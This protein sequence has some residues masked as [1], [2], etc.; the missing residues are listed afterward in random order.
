MREPAAEPPTPPNAFTREFLAWRG[1]EDEPTHAGE[2]STA[3]PWK[4]E[5]APDGRH[6]VLREWE[7]LAEGFAPA[8]VFLA[9][10]PA[11]LLAALL[12]IHG[13]DPL[14]LLDAERKPGGFPLRD[15]SG[16]TVGWLAAY[17]VDLARALHLGLALLRSPRG[18]AAFLESAGPVAEEQIGQIRYQAV[19]SRAAAPDAGARPDGQG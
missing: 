2:A 3:G 9:A 8:G 5:T 10:E 12:P 1:E 7:S 14:V 4:V 16:D 15:G 6:A 18:L 17:D 11:R 19:R 13:R